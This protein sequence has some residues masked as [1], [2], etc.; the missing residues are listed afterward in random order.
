MGGTMRRAACP[1]ERVPPAEEQYVLPP[2]TPI[3]LRPRRSRFCVLVTVIDE[4]PRLARQLARMR[5]QMFAIDVIVCDGGSTDGST[6]RQRMHAAGVRALLVTRD[7]ERFS[8]SLRIGFAYAL[9]EGYD[10]VITVDGNDKDGVEAIPSFVEQLERGFDFVQGSRFLPGGGHE[11]TPWSRY[12]AIRLI[13]APLVRRMSRFP[14]TDTTNGFRGHS[15]RLLRDPRL[16]A[17]R[18]LFDGYELPFY[19]AVRSPVLGLRVTELPVERR[20]PPGAVPTK[21]RRIRGPIE[22]LA[23]LARIASGQLDPPKSI[24]WSESLEQHRAARGRTP[25]NEPFATPPWRTLRFTPNGS[26]KLSRTTIQLPR[27]RSNSER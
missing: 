5:P 23:V 10:G 26:P 18:P 21:I 1:A 9:S 3:V 15:A 4:G 24:P 19:L 6:D 7:H 14:Y 17:F 20:Y 2:F 25:R 13:H 16:Q 11:R 27:V 8:S 22:L 12:L